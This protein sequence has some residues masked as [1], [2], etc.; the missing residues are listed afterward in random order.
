MGMIT[1][2]MSVTALLAEHELTHAIPVASPKKETSFFSYYRVP[3]L[4]RTFN[5]PNPFMAKRRMQASVYNHHEEEKSTLSMFV[6]PTLLEQ[7]NTSRK[8]RVSGKTVMDEAG[9]KPN[10]GGV[11][12]RSKCRGIRHLSLKH[13]S[14]VSP[15]DNGLKMVNEDVQVTS[16][17]NKQGIVFTSPSAI[18]ASHGTA[19]SPPSDEKRSYRIDAKPEPVL[20]KKTMERKHHQIIPFIQTKA[21]LDRTFN[22]LLSAAL[23]CIFHLLNPTSISYLRVPGNRS[24]R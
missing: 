18:A 21:I 10:I 4:E 23:V 24:A 22:P 7:P 15:T 2:P 14:S 3:D 13:A 17:V 1:L 8:G 20:S 12:K 9:C 19:T 5:L 6:F 16:S 11:S